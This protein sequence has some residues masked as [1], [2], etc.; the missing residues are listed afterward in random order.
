MDEEREPFDVDARVRSA[1][2]PGEAVTR[3]ILTAALEDR[4]VAPDT[5][6][7]MVPLAVAFAVAIVAA[8]GLWRWRAV[9]PPAAQLRELAITGN[10][11]VVVVASADGR[12][13]VVGPASPRTTRG[14]YVIVVS[15]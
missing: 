2:T 15:Q 13:W 3:R 8:A 6:R 10:R 12:R 1:V 14:S 7:W 4:P 11:S 5:R 9:S